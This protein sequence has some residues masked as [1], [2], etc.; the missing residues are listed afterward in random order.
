ML[1]PD[2]AY[3]KTCTPEQLLLRIR[4]EVNSQR[5]YHTLYHTLYMHE[6][7][8]HYVLPRVSECLAGSYKLP[9]FAYLCKVSPHSV[10]F[11]VWESTG[12]V[13]VLCSLHLITWLLF[14]PDTHLV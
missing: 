4:N 14:F 10:S 6:V 12:M 13:A 7:S 5:L 8:F 3:T 2:I 11:H 9:H 1:P